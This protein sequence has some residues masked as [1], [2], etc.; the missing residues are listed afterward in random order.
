MFMYTRPFVN[1]VFE[2]V[3]DTRLKLFY[4]VLQ[5]LLLFVVVVVVS[6]YCWSLRF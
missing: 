4:T 6:V 2:T 1:T 3:N 5:L